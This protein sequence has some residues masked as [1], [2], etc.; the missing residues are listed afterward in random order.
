[1]S[2]AAHQTPCDWVSEDKKDD[3]YS[4]CCLLCGKRKR[5]APN[6][7]D[8]GI[9]PYNLVGQ[10]GS[11]ILLS[12]RI[13]VINPDVLICDPAMPAKRVFEGRIRGRS[14]GSWRQVAEAHDL[15]DALS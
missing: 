3:R 5:G 14:A 15:A 10:C 13:T 2:V 12:R 7:N 11:R 4:R 8:V 1:M 9:Q 6:N